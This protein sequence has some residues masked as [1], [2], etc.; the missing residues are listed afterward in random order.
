MISAEILS[1]EIKTELWSYFSNEGHKDTAIVRYINAAVQYVSILKNF[2]FNQYDTTVTVVEWTESYDIPYQIETFFIKRSWEEVEFWNF[3]DFHRWDTEI[4]I[5]W[6]K[7]LCRIPG[8][9]TIFYRGYAPQIT[10]LDDSIDIPSHFKDAI[11][12]WALHFWYKDIK[13]YSKATENMNIFKWMVNDYATREW[14]P[15]PNKTKRLAKS[16]SKTF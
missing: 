9:Y 8:V 16:K 12:V 7:F 2:S 11:F 5:Y 4:W 14:N 1:Q 13:A 15:A 10:K 3:Q 6:E